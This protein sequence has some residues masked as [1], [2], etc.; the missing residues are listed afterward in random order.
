MSIGGGWVSRLWTPPAP[1][2]FKVRSVLKWCLVTNDTL[3]TASHL[4]AKRPLL[5]GQLTLTI[6]ERLDGTPYGY[7]TERPGRKLT[8]APSAP[9]E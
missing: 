2:L 7:P 8:I 5:W 1:R 3:P 9:N 4:W 6:P